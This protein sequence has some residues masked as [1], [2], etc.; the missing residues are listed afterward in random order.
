MGPSNFDIHRV[1]WDSRK[2]GRFWS[3]LTS[4]PHAERSYFSGLFGDRILTVA[5]QH[6][7]LRDARILDY[8][9][10]PGLLLKKMLERHLHASGL[11]FSE[12]SAN[13]ARGNCHN[14]Q[15]FGGVTVASELPS[16]V[17]SH[18]LDVIFL[19][20]VVEHLLP[21]QRDETLQEVSRLLAPGGHLVLTTPH[22]EDL[23]RVETVCPDCGCVFH[24]WQ[25]VS[26]F[27]PESLIGLLRKY[28]F[29][30][31]LC[32]ATTLDARWYGRLLRKARRVIHGRKAEADEPHL[33]YI[34]RLTQG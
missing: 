2:V 22:N 34:G 5:E 6:L 28:G 17:E 27:S 24:P 30:P 4:T 1:E 33:F 3:Y 29:E 25:H 16:S 7:P 26:S 20:E 15:T 14:Y 31:R 23:G 11:E 32:Q 12:E 13:K 18:S 19:V 8:G 21:Q 10:G 9:C